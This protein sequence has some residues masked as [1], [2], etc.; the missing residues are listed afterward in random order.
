MTGTVIITTHMNLYKYHK[1]KIS[2]YPSEKYLITFHFIKPIHE[3]SVQP[4]IL[5]IRVER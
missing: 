3:S 4:R 5:N 1:C 2:Y